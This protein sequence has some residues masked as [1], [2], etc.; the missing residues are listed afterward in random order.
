MKIAVMT[1]FFT[2]RNVDVEGQMF[3]LQI[4]KIYVEL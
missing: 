3:F 2:K 4:Y 1:G